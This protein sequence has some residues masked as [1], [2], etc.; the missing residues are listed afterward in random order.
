[1]VIGLGSR[2]GS[3]TSFSNLVI[4]NSAVEIAKNEKYC[5]YNVFFHH[6]DEYGIEKNGEKK[7]YLHGFF[8][9]LID[10]NCRI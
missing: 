8:F 6:T 4:L 1:M 7:R 9:T 3:L 2:A 10:F 5:E